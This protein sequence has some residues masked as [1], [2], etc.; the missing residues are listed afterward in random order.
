[1]ATRRDERMAASGAKSAEAAAEVA[2]QRTEQIKLEMASKKADRANSPREA[3][4]Q[5]GLN[6]AAPVTGFA[7]GKAYA[8]WINNRAIASVGDKSKELKS[9]ASSISR[10]LAVSANKKKLGVAAVAKLSGA[11][12]TADRMGLTRIKG[13]AGVGVAAVVLAEGAFSRFVAAPQSEGKTRDVLGAVGTASVFLAS[14]MVA[15]RSVQNATLAK[16]PSAAALAKIETARTMIQ[17]MGG[18]AAGK[19]AMPLLAKMSPA[20]AAGARLGARAIP[21]VGWALAGAGIAKGGYDAW[22][23]GGTASDIAIS[24][25]RGFVGLDAR[26]SKPMGD[27]R[28]ESARAAL[29]RAAAA[30]NAASGGGSTLAAARRVAAAGPSSDGMTKAYVRQQGGKTVNV[31]SYKTPR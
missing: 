6:V 17:T 25:A 16:L 4:W 14:T 30:R 26:V 7:G 3:A 8:N 1:M 2:R 29:G 23:K 9:L 24:A 11:V 27:A 31:K 10:Q 5:L 20:I 19:V 28:I 18:S 15:T 21:V 22:K 12:R 13:P